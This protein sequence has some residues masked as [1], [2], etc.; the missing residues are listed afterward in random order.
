M[1]WALTP[2][3]DLQRE[4]QKTAHDFARAEIAPH[5]QRWDRD[6]YFEPALVEKLGSL[7]FMGMLIPEQ[8]DGLGL[9]SLTYLIALEEIAICD[10]SAA[11]CGR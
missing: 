10:A 8:Y 11:S 9:D 7:G 4:I 3:T 1:A 2:L 5:S 6:Q